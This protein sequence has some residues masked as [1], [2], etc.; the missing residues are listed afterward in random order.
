M[1]RKKER[2]QNSSQVFG[3][4]DWKYDKTTHLCRN[5]KDWEAGRRDELVLEMLSLWVILCKLLVRWLD[6]QM[7]STKERLK[8]RY[9]YR[10]Y[11]V[12]G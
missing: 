12:I 7:E 3:L 5:G 8:L 9:K 6:L 1:E 11:Q 10:S 2:R 4:E